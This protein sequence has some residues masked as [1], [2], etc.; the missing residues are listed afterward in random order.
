MIAITVLPISNRFFLK[1]LKQLNFL[2]KRGRLSGQSFGEQ[3]EK[4]QSSAIQIYIVTEKEYL[5][6]DFSCALFWAFYT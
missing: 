6:G 4:T 1:V 3:R 2:V 5:Y